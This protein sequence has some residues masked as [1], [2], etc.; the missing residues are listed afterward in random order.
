[1]QFANRTYLDSDCK[2]PVG[3][4]NIEIRYRAPEP[5]VDARDPRNVTRLKAAYQKA[6]W[7][8]SCDNMT[9][10]PPDC[11]VYGNDSYDFC[12]T[13]NISIGIPGTQGRECSPNSTDVNSCDRLCCDRGYICLKGIKI[14]K[15]YILVEWPYP[16]LITIYK[17]IVMDTCYC[18]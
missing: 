10:W 2:G 16:H 1:M 12:C 3:S 5:T 13:R 4:C 9:Y 8:D 7:R 14:V 6:V 18:F 15:D 17:T 11:V